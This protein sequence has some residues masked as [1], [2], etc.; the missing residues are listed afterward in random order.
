MTLVVYHRAVAL[1]N[2]HKSRSIFQEF[3]HG[4]GTLAKGHMKWDIFVVH[5]VNKP[6]PSPPTHIDM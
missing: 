6:L 5:D 2:D 1:I 3:D 4:S